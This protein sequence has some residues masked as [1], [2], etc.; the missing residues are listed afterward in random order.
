MA[1]NKSEE[2]ALI[3]RAKEDQDALGELYERYVDRIYSYLY[4]RTGNV[5]DAE[6]LTARVFVRAVRHIG[7]YEDRGAPFS[8]WLYSIARNMLSNWYRD[9]SK[10][11]V[12][13]I[14]GIAQQSSGDGPERRIELGEDREVLLGA[15]RKLPADRQELLVLK[16]VEQLP[17]AEI[18][19]I[20]GRS[21]GAIK[22]L[23]HRTLLSLR[24]DLTTRPAGNHEEQSKKCRRW[25]FGRKQRLPLSP[26]A[27]SDSEN[28]QTE[29]VSARNDLD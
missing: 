21:E 7:N 20:M 2:S 3:E 5:H 8:A 14:E 24:D 9:H 29:P 25:R 22:A 23:Y 4:Y 15:I 10:R 19:Q 12:L 11:K 17:N 6:D 1:D 27:T 16:Y 26:E 28:G 18:G 13:P